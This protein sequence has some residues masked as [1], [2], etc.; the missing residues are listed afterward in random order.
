MVLV[1][2]KGYLQTLLNALD[3]PIRRTLLPAFEH[4]VDTLKIGSGDKA[5]NFAWYRFESTTASS[6][7]VE[8]SVHHGLGQVPS[9]LIPVLD[10]SVTGSQLVPLTVSRAPDAQRVYL[11]SAST[12]A[13]ITV[14]LEA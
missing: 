7:G 2:S 11:T 10:L 12:S 4:V 9:K 3:A 14:Y 5:L 6:A 13:I 1:A 8:F